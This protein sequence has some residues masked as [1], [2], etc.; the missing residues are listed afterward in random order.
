MKKMGFAKSNCNYDEYAPV[1]SRPPTLK[2]TSFI[3]EVPAPDVPAECVKE[4]VP[5][6]E[7]TARCEQNISAYSV[8]GTTH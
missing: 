2:P 4:M 7:C 8:P 5:Y 3:G 6:T 1:F